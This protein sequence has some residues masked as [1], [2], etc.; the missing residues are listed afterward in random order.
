MDFLNKRK[1][2]VDFSAKQKIMRSQSAFVF[3]IAWGIVNQ[4]SFLLQDAEKI[5][6]V[7][8]IT[9]IFRKHLSEVI[10]CARLED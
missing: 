5:N 3:C 10:H 4:I 6:K 1:G 2:V 8:K 9:T 7:Q